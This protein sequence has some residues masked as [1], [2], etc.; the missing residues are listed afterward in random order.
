MTKLAIAYLPTSSLE[1]FANNSRTHSDEQVGQ[2]ARSIQEFGFTNPILIDE[3]GVII[4]GHGRVMAA[5]RLGLKDVPTITLGH[6][7]DEKRRAYVIADNKLAL[8]AGWD[9]DLLRL[10]IQELGDLAGVIGF[11]PDELNVLMNGWEETA[12]PSTEGKG[13]GLASI[14]VKISD[15]EKR[16]AKQLIENALTQAGIDFEYA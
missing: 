10:E 14:K 16:M 6:L 5:E 8:N 11:D 1:A 7:S 4:A 9:N 12:A 13:D 2:I 3:H 15:N